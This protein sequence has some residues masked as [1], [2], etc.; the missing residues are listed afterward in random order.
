[1]ELVADISSLPE[2]M[3]RELI[4][5]EQA[6]AEL[7]IQAQRQLKEAIDA[8]EPHRHVEG[9][10]RKLT[11]IHPSLGARLRV[12]FGMTCLHDP[13]FLRS[14][15]RDN[16]F[17]RAN[18]APAKLVVRVNGLRD[19]KIPDARNRARREG[20]G[21]GHVAHPARVGG[22]EETSAL[23]PK[24]VPVQKQPRP[25]PSRLPFSLP[26]EFPCAR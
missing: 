24:R 16:P 2:R 25:F 8:M 20:S 4:R 21:Q 22:A 11:T 1:M 26:R 14:L 9:L 12:K 15:L 13:D 3:K 23:P 7:A 17:L 10:G 18:T 19:Q 6:R 5:G